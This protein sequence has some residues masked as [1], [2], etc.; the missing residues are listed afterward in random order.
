MWRERLYILQA[1]REAR[2]GRGTETS[3]GYRRRKKKKRERRTRK[4]GR[5]QEYMSK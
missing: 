2:E 4:K 5:K 3:V 1:L